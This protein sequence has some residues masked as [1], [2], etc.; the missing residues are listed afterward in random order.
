MDSSIPLLTRKSNIDWKKSAEKIHQSVHRRTSRQIFGGEK[1]FCPNFSKVCRKVFCAIFANNSFP[2][3]DHFLVWPPKKDLHVFFC[4]RW[5]P[6]LEVKQRWVPFVPGFSGFC[7]YFEWFCPDFRE[8][9]TFGGSLAPPAPPPP[10]TLNQC[11]TVDSKNLCTGVDRASEKFY[12]GVRRPI[13]GPQA[14]IALVQICVACLYNYQNIDK[15]A[16]MLRFTNRLIVIII[17]TTGLH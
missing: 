8:I 3:K 16:T 15:I 9:K 7:P 6:F 13:P 17:L 2:I 1:D 5:A 4:K 14:S 12:Q 10:T 11:L